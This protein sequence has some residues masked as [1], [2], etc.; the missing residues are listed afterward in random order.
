MSNRP[1]TCAEL[2]QAFLDFY[3]NKGHQV[4]PGISLVPTDPSLLLT[5]AGVVQFR[6]YIEGNAIPPYSRVVSCQRCIRTNDITQVGKTPTHLTFFEMLGTWSFGDYYKKETLEWAWEFLTDICGLDP[7]R[8]WGT[9]H[10]GDWEAYQIWRA[11][12]PENKIIRN[13]S[14]F[15]GPVAETG[16]CGPC[17][18][19][20]YDLG[21]MYSKCNRSAGPLVTDC[22]PGCGCGRFV[23]VWNHVFT[24]QYK[25]GELF[26]GEAFTPLAHKNIDTGMGLER[27]AMIVQQKE[28]VFDIDALSYLERVVRKSL[29]LVKPDDLWKVRAI[30]DHCRAIQQMVVDGIVPS[31]KG[32]GYV[33]RY[34]I[35]RALLLAYT[36]GG[37]GNDQ[38]HEWTLVD[39]YFDTNYHPMVSSYSDGDLSDVEIVANADVLVALLDREE[40]YFAKT[41]RTGLKR[42]FKVA[43]EFRDSN[44]VD[45]ETVF[46]LYDTYGLPIEITEE[47]LEDFGLVVDRVGF[48]AAMEKHR[49]I[50]RGGKE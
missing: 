17:S 29:P 5:G 38:M 37:G 49:A 28:D 20:F 50:S 31:N 15:W 3:E 4:V 45:G 10:P 44:L 25:I 12:V 32:R 33:L 42:L 9:V 21:P 47:V 43:H 1:V 23:E 8:L 7:N 40:K 36:C 19:M 26:D 22:N 6:D 39:L 41:L 13:E 16:A 48:D 2:R 14:N 18:E 24:D 35:R 11:L 34:L 46:H 30:A 27:L